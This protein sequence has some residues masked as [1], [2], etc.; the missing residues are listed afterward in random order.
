[1]ASTSPCPHGQPIELC[2][3]CAVSLP[4]QSATLPVRDDPA[5]TTPSGETCTT[6]SVRVAG[7]EVLGQLGRGGMGVVY[8]ARHLALKRVVALKMIGSGI[9]AEPQELARFKA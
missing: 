1:M 4:E 5:L 8:K 9:H 6:S 2:P 3:A 7:Y